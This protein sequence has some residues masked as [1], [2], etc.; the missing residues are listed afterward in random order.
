MKYGTVLNCFQ[1]LQVGNIMEFVSQCQTIL[2]SSPVPILIVD[3]DLSILGSNEAVKSMTRDENGIP[4]AMRCGEALDCIHA[5]ESGRCGSSDYCPECGIRQAVGS[6]CRGEKV[7]RNKT[8]LELAWRGRNIT[9]SLLVSAT[10][11]VD[12]DKSYAVLVLE[13]VSALMQ[14]Q[15]LFTICSSCNKVK[16]AED[17]WQSINDFF[18]E[19]F[20]MR[21][22]H[23]ICKECTKKLYPE[24]CNKS[25]TV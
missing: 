13:D 14:L 21:F 15:S 7:N 3:H 5:I 12:G 19:Q 22:S 23:G 20:G 2:D 10:P 11:L 1:K 8:S 18:F 16:V 4:L 9:L 25:G 6:A 17:G 24:F